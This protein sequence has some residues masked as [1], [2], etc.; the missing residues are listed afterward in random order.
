MSM[1]SLDF[2]SIAANAAKAKADIAAAKKLE[3]LNKAR[4]ARD[5]AVASK[6]PKVTP[7]LPPKTSVANTEAAAL[8]K[9]KAKIEPTSSFLVPDFDLFGTNDFKSVFEVPAAKDDTM[10]AGGGG[11]NYDSSTA[12]TVPTTVAPVASV[13]PTAPVTD[14]NWMDIVNAS[15]AAKNP[16]GP[17]TAREPLPADASIQEQIAYYSRQNDPDFQSI[18][19]GTAGE[20]QSPIIGTARYFQEELA[21][22]RSLG[23]IIAGGV[24]IKGNFEDPYLREYS[25]RLGGSPARLIIPNSSSSAAAGLIGHDDSAKVFFNPGPGIDLNKIYRNL[26]GKGTWSIPEGGGTPGSYDIVYTPKGYDPRAGGSGIFNDY[27]MPVAQGVMSYF[28]PVAGATFAATKAAAGEDLTAGDIASLVTGGLEA[29]GLMVKPVAAK[30]ATATAP[31]TEAIEGVGL[32]GNTY[33][34]SKKALDV[35]LAAA[36]GNLPAAV[37][38]AFGGDLTEKALDSVGLSTDVL[39]EFNVN[40]DDLVKGLLTTEKALVS[41]SDLGDALLKGVGTYIKEGGAFGEGIPGFETPDIIKKLEDVVKVVGSQIDDVILQPVKETVPVLV[42]AAKEAVRPVVEAGSAIN[43]EVVKPVV[44]A[45]GDVAKATGDVIQTVTEPVIDVIDDVLDSSYDAINQLDNFIDDIDLPDINAPDINL[46][47]INLPS[48]NYSPSFSFQTGG[49]GGQGARR[50]P[51][52]AKESSEFMGLGFSPEE[53]E[54][55]RQFA[56]TRR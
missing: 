37:V 31:A 40:Q 6:P 35:A 49:G 56:I 48:L 38:S 12:V 46:P 53:L 14:T 11:I 29:T 21:K 20:D 34:A 13:A 1:F 4:A 25:R 5:A 45:I 51:K 26:A 18:L 16:L 52:E 47:N 41:G 30:A 50:S 2:A 23:D 22:G 8:A 33:E 3:D 10:Y 19:S 36:D 44:G 43:R 9:A 17:S 55:A 42:E 28:N 24:G 54:L 27:L 7:I 32:L 15:L 39:K